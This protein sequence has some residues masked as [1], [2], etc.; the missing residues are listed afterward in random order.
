MSRQVRK[1]DFPTPLRANKTVNGETPTRVVNCPAS[2][3]RPRKYRSSCARNGRRPGYGLF[4]MGRQTSQESVET[5]AIQVHTP[6]V[7]ESN[8][9]LVGI[10]QTGPVAFVSLLLLLLDH[11]ESSE[12]NAEVQ[13]LQ[14]VAK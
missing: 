5:L 14:G 7:P 4:D 3:S 6:P 11:A 2:M 10:S 1:E 8:L 9:D 13:V 12:E